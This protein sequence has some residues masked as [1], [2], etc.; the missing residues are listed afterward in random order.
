MAVT[1]KRPSSWWTSDFITALLRF[2]RSPVASVP[3][4]ADRPS[5]PPGPPAAAGRP[6]SDPRVRLGRL[7]EALAAARLERLGF[8]ILARNARTRHGEIDLIA[9]DGQTLVFAEV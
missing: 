6:R 8:T 7:G 4:P 1:S 9:F 5:P 2:R 3:V